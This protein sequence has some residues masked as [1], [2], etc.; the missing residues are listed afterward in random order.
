MTATLVPAMCA[1]PPATSTDQVAVPLSSAEVAL[2]VSVPICTATLTPASVPV[3]PEIANPAVCS[4]MFT[5]PSPAMV[6]RFS[7][8]ASPATT[9]NVKVSVAWL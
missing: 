6:S 2:R 7:S 1:A 4:A 9:V 8:S 5:V 3:S